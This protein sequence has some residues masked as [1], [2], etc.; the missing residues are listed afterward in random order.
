[1]IIINKIEVNNCYFLIFDMMVNKMESYDK[2]IIGLERP[3]VNVNTD[4]FATNYNFCQLDQYLIIALS[5]LSDAQTNLE[6]TENNFKEL[7]NYSK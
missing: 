5:A 3:L 2:K 6:N 7:K 1:M 4:L